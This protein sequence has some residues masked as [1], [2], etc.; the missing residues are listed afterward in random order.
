VMREIASAIAFGWCSGT[1]RRRER[2]RLL[3]GMG[4]RYDDHT[5]PHVDERSQPAEVV[6][7]AVMERAAVMRHEKVNR[8][9]NQARSS[10]STSP[11]VR[12]T[13]LSW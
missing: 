12:P 1:D 4:H 9:T 5:H 2:T 11:A 7:D 3:R 13:K 10:A 6:L 8:D